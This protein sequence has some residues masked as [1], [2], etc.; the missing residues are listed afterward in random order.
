MS[1]CVICFNSLTNKSIKCYDSKCD[2]IICYECMEQY[3]L[4]S[5]TLPK[6]VN[7]KCNNKYIISQIQD[8]SDK[9]QNIYKKLCLNYFLNT[10]EE[11]IKNDIVK[12]EILI[13]IRDDRVKTVKTFPNAIAKII[14]ICM[15]DRLKKI[16]KTNTEIVN[17]IINNSGRFCMLSYCNGKLDNEFKCLKCETGF[18]KDCERIKK[19]S[20]HICKESDLNSVKYIKNIG[21]CP[22]CNIAIEKSMGC[23]NMKCANCHTMFDYYTGQLADHGGHNSD[24]KIK[25]ELRLS[26]LY[27]EF[28]NEKIILALRQFEREKPP[29]EVE[30]KY[31]KI[32]KN[33]KEYVMNDKKDVNVYSEKIS[34]IFDVYTRMKNDYIVYMKKIS[35]I[36]DLHENGILTYEKL[37]QIV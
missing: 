18:C 23:R 25:E 1:N 19:D 24:I 30:L 37:I 9:Y 28:Y 14:D 16:N 12:D 17:N 27:E 2:A 5:D 15:K 4:S 7:T 21:K 6:C 3:I 11:Q 8:I 33:M 26:S 32:L 20:S 22:N 10:E 31:N 36:Q 35:E 34:K 13:K 29:N